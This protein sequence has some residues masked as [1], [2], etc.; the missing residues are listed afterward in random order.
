MKQISKRLTYANVISTLAIFLVLGGA[1]AVAA[2]QLAKN[3]VGAK[4]LKNGAVTTAKIKN[5]AVTGAK[6]KDGTITGAKLVLGS[7][8]QVPTAANAANAAHAASADNATTVGGQTVQKIAW[9]V[10]KNT[11]A[12]TIFNQ[13]GLVITGSCNASGEIAV[14]ATPTGEEAEFQLFGNEGNAFFNSENSSFTGPTSLVN[15]S[16]NTPAKKEGGGSFAYGTASGHVATMTY[17]FDFAS[18]FHLK[19]PGCGFFGQIIYG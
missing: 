8:G 11:P 3:S 14:A 2:S 7:L 4:Q 12:T 15:G 17:G 19:N 9:V 10:P 13:V 5:G 18:S 1:S 6:I 16:G